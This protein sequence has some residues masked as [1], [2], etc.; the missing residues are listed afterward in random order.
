MTKYHIRYQEAR[1]IF[2]P[3]T[4]VTQAR[5]ALEAAQSTIET[6]IGQSLALLQLDPNTFVAYPKEE[7]ESQ[8]I[9]LAYKNKCLHDDTFVLKIQP[10]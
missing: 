8:N 5:D 4:F 9:A 1:Q 7:F 2:K 3:K 6:L 10:E